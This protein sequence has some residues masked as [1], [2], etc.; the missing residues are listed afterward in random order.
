MPL[1]TDLPWVLRTTT[2]LCLA[3][4]CVGCFTSEIRVGSGS[5]DSVAWGDSEFGETD[6]SSSD[7]DAT[8][9][10]TE[11]TGGE[12]E[13]DGLP[14]LSDQ[15]QLCGNGEVDMDEDCDD[16]GASA[17]CD[18]D[19]TVP[20]CGD[21]VVNPL[22]GESCDPGSEGDEPCNEDCNGPM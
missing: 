3:I 9:S 4:C 18:A 7:S 19:C 11:G 5:G 14:E 16:G 20:A 21:G 13:A 6:D 1:P 12:T 10:E 15:P 22:A 8:D 17:V 2:H